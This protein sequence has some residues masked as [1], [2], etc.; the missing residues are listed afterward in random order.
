MFSL[1]S[2]SSSLQ[3][4]IE[5]GGGG[6]SVY[7]SGCLDSSFT[8]ISNH[9]LKP[10][11]IQQIVKAHHKVARSCLEIVLLEGVFSLQ[12]YIQSSSKHEA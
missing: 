5:L 2:G 10:Y 6:V 4:S 9:T 1:D 12:L 7:W 3:M 8:C 11:S